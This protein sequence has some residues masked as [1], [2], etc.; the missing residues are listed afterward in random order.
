MHLQEYK[1]DFLIIS[2]EIGKSKPATLFFLSKFG[3]EIEKIIFYSNSTQNIIWN[4]F[5][6]LLTAN[7]NLLLNHP[8]NKKLV[9]FETEY[10]KEIDGMTT[11]KKLKEFIPLLKKEIEC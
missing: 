2:D 4:E 5:D 10:N 11:I 3:C 1:I 9:K 6:I 8:T 7:P